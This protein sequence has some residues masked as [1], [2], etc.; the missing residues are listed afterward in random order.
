MA[1]IV[2]K[3]SRKAG[4]NVPETC[5]TEGI[6]SISFKCWYKKHIHVNGE[7]LNKPHI[8]HDNGLHM[9]NNGICLSIIYPAFVA[10]CF[11][12]SGY[13]LKCSVY[14]GILTCSRVW[15]KTALDWT[16]MTTGA[17]RVC[18][19]DYRRRQV[20]ECA[21]TWYKPCIQPTE[22]EEL[23]RPSNLSTLLFESETTN[24]LTVL[25]FCDVHIDTSAT[26][27]LLQCLR[28][29]CGCRAVQTNSAESSLVLL[30]MQLLSI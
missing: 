14:S 1:N 24:G 22:T 25:L 6:Q 11:P 7:S 10:P 29:I 3:C 20:G 19:E 21:D 8:D 12:R 18:C 28:V 13:A 26:L 27:N 9:W 16:V 23:Y 30:A 4:G 17:T 2:G 5:S 15:F